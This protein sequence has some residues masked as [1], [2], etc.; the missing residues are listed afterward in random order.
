MYRR[1]DISPEDFFQA[2][3]RVRRTVRD[4]V[5]RLIEWLDSTIDCDVDC[6]ADDEP[7][8]GD[9]DLEPSLGSFD[10]MSDQLKAWKPR[11]VRMDSHIDATDVELDA[12]DD[13]PSL[14]IAPERELQRTA[15]LDLEDQCDD[16]GDQSDTG[17]GDMDGLQEQDPKAFQFC[18]RRVE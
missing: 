17:I 13:E 8:D 9:P 18:G 16:E 2:L 14:C 15:S 4:E 5:E 7:C 10:R 11:P 1:V 12:S 3:G 6:A